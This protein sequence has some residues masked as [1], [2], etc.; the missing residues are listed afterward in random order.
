MRSFTRFL[1]DYVHRRY[2]PPFFLLLAYC[3]RFTAFLLACVLLFAG[4]TGAKEEA[5]KQGTPQ[6]GVELLF[7]AG[8]GRQAKGT[9]LSKEQKEAASLLKKLKAIEK[10][11]DINATDKQGQTALMHAAAANNR[12]AVCWLVAKGADATARNKK[13]ET[14]AE[15]AKDKQI[16]EFLTVISRMNEPL[17]EGEKEISARFLDGENERSI[18]FSAHFPPAYRQPEKPCTLTELGVLL[19]NPQIKIKSDSW[20]TSNWRELG[21]LT[22]EIMAIYLQRGALDIS[23]KD[24]KGESVWISQELTPE[25]ITLACALGTSPPQSPEKKLLVAFASNNTALVEQLIK[26]TPSLINSPFVRQRGKLKD[27]LPLL[28]FASSKKMIDLLYKLGINDSDKVTDDEGKIHAHRR[29]LVIAELIERVPTDN[30][31][32]VLSCLKEHGWQLPGGCLYHIISA[33]NATLTESEREKKALSFIKAGAD[34]NPRGETPLHLAAQYDFLAVAAMLIEKGANI[35]AA[36]SEGHSSR[37]AGETPLHFAN[38]LEMATLLLKA[39]ADPNAKD[40]DGR[41]PLFCSNVHENPAIVSALIQAGADV[42]A[43]VASGSTRGSTP[44]FNAWNPAVVFALIQ[45]GADVNA[46]SAS[47][48]TP[49]FNASNPAVVSALIQAG[50]DVNARN[51]NGETPLFRANGP[52]VSALIQA[53]ADVNARNHNGETP[54]LWASTSGKPAAVVSALIQAGADVNARSASGSTPLFRAGN[55]AVVSALIQAGADVNARDNNGNTPIFWASASGKPAAVSA[56]IQA[57][58]DVNARND[59]GETPIFWTGNPAVVSALTQ[60]GADVNARDNNG[61]TPLFG[62]HTPLFWASEKIPEVIFPA[63]IQAGADVNAKNDKGETPLFWTKNPAVVSALIQAGADVNARDNAGKTV[64]QYAKEKKRGDDITKLLKERGA[65]EETV[66]LP[67]DKKSAPS[68]KKKNVPNERDARGR[69]RLM[70][71]VRKNGSEGEIQSL[72]RQGADVNARDNDG[73]TAL[74]HLFTVVGNI[75]ARLNALLVAHPD[76]NLATHKGTT[77]LMIL[78]VCRDPKERVSRVKKLLEL[79][80]K[81]DLKDSEGRTA[82]MRYVEKDDNAEALKLLLDAGADPK[83]RNRN[84]K[85]LL[86]LAQ[87][88]KRTAC[89]RLLRERLTPP[90]PAKHLPASSSGHPW[91]SIIGGVLLVLLIGCVG[92]HLRRRK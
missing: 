90:S 83:L 69:T 16:Q 54:L 75:D 61:N 81:V 67:G 79:H 89:V 9:K 30:M 12:L 86:Q 6:Q 85:T 74:H 39:G 80:A 82:A 65:K 1:H 7:P 51:D 60:A 15:L 50:A 18:L 84:G 5:I 41:T 31:D 34:I 17:N 32:E 53:G 36:L 48:S 47:G 92:L 78:D 76:V 46:R 37:C 13:G 20:W 19:R 25:P 56:L 4:A 52:A 29:E 33:D 21:E 63:L 3:K 28:C 70:L 8:T 58:A 55:P 24:E 38:S 62:G 64:L 57:S 68:N 27:P 44:L 49:L 2:P 66:T 11:G 26:E 45:A 23:T 10:G 35:Q 88:H 14:A 22:P 72:L 71:A 73:N 42:N 43:R 59:N 77:P 40:A 91:W 87:Q